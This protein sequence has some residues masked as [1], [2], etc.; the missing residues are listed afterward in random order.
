MYYQLPVRYVIKY[1]SNEQL[2]LTLGKIEK[3][4]KRF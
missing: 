4:Q 1:L 3:K 2:I